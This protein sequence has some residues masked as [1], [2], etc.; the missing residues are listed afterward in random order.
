[1]HTELQGL[2]FTLDQQ[3]REQATVTGHYVAKPRE[4]STP[5]VLPMPPHPVKW[6]VNK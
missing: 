3:L 4:E 1:M 6:T 2:K 5:S